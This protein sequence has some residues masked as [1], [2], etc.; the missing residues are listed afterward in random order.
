VISPFCHCLLPEELDEG[1]KIIYFVALPDTSS[2]YFFWGDLTR[3]AVTKFKNNSPSR[4]LYKYRPNEMFFPRHRIIALN[5]NMTVDLEPVVITE[6]LACTLE[7]GE[8][9]PLFIAKT[10]T[11]DA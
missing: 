4:C 5:D 9:K 3:V 2:A 10:L 7:T 11:R 1:L 8:D 6:L